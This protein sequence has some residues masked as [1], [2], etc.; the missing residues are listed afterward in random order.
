[1]ERGGRLGRMCLR[2]EGEWYVR[3]VGEYHVIGEGLQTMLGA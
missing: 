3:S 1:V 2:S